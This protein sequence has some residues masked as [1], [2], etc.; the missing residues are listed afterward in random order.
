[1]FAIGGCFI[2]FGRERE[3]GARAQRGFAAAALAHGGRIAGHALASG[4]VTAAYEP[5]L[6]ALRE[7]PLLQTAVRSLPQAPEVLLVNATGADHPRRAGL[8]LHLGAVLE[9]P[10]VGVTHRPLLAVGEWPPLQ[11]VGASSPLELD[12]D[13]VGCW[14]RTRAHARPLAVHPAWR[15]E[16]ATACEVVL[17]GLGGVRAPEPLREARRLAR[18]AR[19]RATSD[20]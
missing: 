14:L 11:A 1:M 17:A 2:C 18:R 13:T 15:T 10:T 20:C 12:G 7:G 8:A 16:L 3:D 5:G 9:L 6:L 19:A 4:E